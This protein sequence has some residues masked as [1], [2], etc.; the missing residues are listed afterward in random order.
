MLNRALKRHLAASA[1]HCP[2]TT[3]GYGRMFALAAVIGLLPLINGILLRTYDFPI[4][5]P[6]LDAVFEM[7]WLYLCVEIGIIFW[8][9]IQGM[10]YKTEFFKL[11]CWSRYA[12]LVFISLFWASSLFLAPAPIYSVTR[13]LYWFVHIACGFAMAFLIVSVNRE[14]LVRAVTIMMGTFL[15]YAV[16]VILHFVAAPVPLSEPIQW[17]ALVPGCLSIRHFGM[18]AAFP[19]AAWIGLLLAGEKMPLGRLGS[20]AILSLAFAALFWSGTRSGVVAILVAVPVVLF[21]ARKIPAIGDAA[22]VM[23]SVLAGALL[24]QLLLP[25][26]TAF[27]MFRINRIPGLSGSSLTSGR[28]ELWIF[29]LQMFAKS[30]LLG[31]GEGSFYHLLASAGKG[32][33][34]QPHNF[35]VQ[36]LMSWGVIAGGV[37][38]VMIAKATLRLHRS[39]LNSALMIAPLAAL[40]AI[41]VIAML[42]SA[43]FTMRT[44]VPAIFFWILAEKIA[45]EEALHQSEIA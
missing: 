13:A 9:R 14:V 16:F 11:T 17:A 8:A 6:V 44:I 15:I 32:H 28:T 29:G 22:V 12:L 19:L 7:E 10:S 43:L 20:F 30:P 24:S 40:D 33:H 34:L 31:W 1:N 35:I 38:L 37:A 2:T 36:F 5:P 39:V 41:L 21:C 45:A 18:L 25:A 27:G 3:S 23:F 4:Q 42:D 26:D